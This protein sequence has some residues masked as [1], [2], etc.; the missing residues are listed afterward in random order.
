MLP[1]LRDPL[2]ART[3]EIFN[4]KI[5]VSA[6]LEHFLRAPPY[7]PLWGEAGKLTFQLAEINTI[8]SRIRATARGILDVAPRH[9]F[10]DDGSEIAHLVVFFRSPDV[11]G[12]VVHN[13]SRGLERSKECAANVFDVDERA[14]R[15]P[16]RLNQNAPRR[17]RPGYEIIEDH[18]KTHEWRNAISCGIAKEDGAET[19]VCQ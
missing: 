16:I 4:S 18:I 11:E 6:G 9:G 1:D 7:I 3:L 12:L 14:P 17:K 8:G 2:E 10:P 15:R 5:D 13:R 19:S